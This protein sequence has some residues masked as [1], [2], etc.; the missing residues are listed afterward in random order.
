MKMLDKYLIKK[1]LYIFLLVLTSIILIFI[2]IDFVENVNDFLNAPNYSIF[3]VIR[4]YLVYVP[5]I[6][7]LVMPMITLI[8]SLFAVMSM[9]RYNEITALKSAGVSL[10]R[11]ISPLIVIGIFISIS[12]IFFD[13]YVVSY[14][15]QKRLEIHNYELKKKNKRLENRVYNKLLNDVDGN[16]IYFMEFDATLN[17]GKQI[18]I[19]S[20][21]GAQMTKRIDARK[22]IWDENHW[23]LF[24]AS[25]RDFTGERTLYSKKDT[26]DLSL[27]GVDPSELRKERKRT[28]EMSFS[29]LNQ[30][31]SDLKLMGTKTTR[32]E[33]ARNSKLSYPF[34]NLIILIFGATLAANKRRSGPALGFL[35]SLVIVFGYFFVFKFGE[36]FGQNGE[37]SPILASWLGNIVFGIAAAVTLLKTRQ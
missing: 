34:A 35:V 19:Q 10:L 21:D 17:K 24:N 14:A 1:F 20:F 2:V 9:S 22:F 4:Y 28:E 5:N 6:I 31:I 23:L 13:E 15:N 8:A 7:Y 30:F 11:I 33:V 36:I 26:L 12:M 37:I 32:W 25:I 18:T 29:D 3:L 16:K 27:K